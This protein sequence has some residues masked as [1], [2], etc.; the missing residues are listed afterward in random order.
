MEIIS[1]KIPGVVVAQG[2]PRA[3]SM[4]GKVR[5][6]DPPKSRE[7]KKYVKDVAQYYAPTMPLEGP[8]SMRI[9]ICREYL[10]SFTKKQRFQAEDGALMPITKPDIDN[11]AKSIM[12][13]LN[14]LIYKDDSQIVELVLLKKYAEESCAYVEINTI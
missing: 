9:V 12:D 3:S 2:R 11:T 4:G 10:K 7:Y 8:L 14:G 6:Y 5:M 13:S 1:F